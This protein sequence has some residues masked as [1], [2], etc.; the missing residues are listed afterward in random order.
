LVPHSGSSSRDSEPNGAA[1]DVPDDP[2]LTGMPR[3]H[4]LILAAGDSRRFGGGTAKQ[5]LLLAGKPVVR[6]SVE[7]FLAAGVDTV[8]VVT[9]SDQRAEAEAAV[10][11][12]PVRVVDGGATRDAS[13]RAGLAALGDAEGD[14]IVLIHDGAR[15]LVDAETIQRCLAA[16]E[17]APAVTVAAPATD[18]MLEVELGAVVAVPPRN[19]MF[20]AQTPQGFRFDIITRAHAAAAATPDFLPTD[21]CGVVNRFLPDT[22]IA[23]VMG[24]P[25]NLKITTP[26][27]L[28]RAAGLLPLRTGEAQESRSP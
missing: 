15:P 5:F 9:G 26:E 24:T 21:D 7:A 4:A 13:T 1:D 27:D 2:I 19:R 8:V 10:A 20:R 6:H 25:R 23:V 28:P 14:D 12:L 22:P 17:D 11:G 16:L 18:T 3:T